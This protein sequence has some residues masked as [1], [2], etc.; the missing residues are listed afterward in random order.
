MKYRIMRWEEEYGIW[1]ILHV[2]E[3]RYRAGEVLEYFHTV[4]YK[5]MEVTL[6]VWT[7]KEYEN[8]VREYKVQGNFGEGL[9]GY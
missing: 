5:G 1:K 7:D 4:V 2:G 6:E 8:A 9:Y 3:S